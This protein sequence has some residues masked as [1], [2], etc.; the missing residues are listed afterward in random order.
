[1]HE[2][3][4][5]HRSSLDKRGVCK[6]VCRADEPNPTAA[7]KP[8]APGSPMRPTH[9]SDPLSLQLI[10]SAET[11]NE[12]KATS[13]S[14]QL[15]LKQITANTNRWLWPMFH[16]HLHIYSFLLPGH[17]PLVKKIRGKG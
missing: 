13:T 17:Y 4:K 2:L 8:F 9:T 1:V 6:H 16:I 7:T 11:W 5:N 3:V 15:S 10:Q 14:R 12:A